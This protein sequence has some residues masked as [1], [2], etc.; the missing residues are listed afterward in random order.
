MAQENV[1]TPEEMARRRAHY[2]SGLA[3][4][5]GTFGI[6]NVF[7]W[8]L[9]LGLGGGGADWAFWI[10]GAWG[11]ALAFHGLAYLIQGR[12]LEERRTRQYLQEERRREA[13]STI[14]SD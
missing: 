12:Q 13:G 2:L 14:S 6:I 5:A 11:F 1:R 10:T 8:I 9:D 4:H 3:W 7:L